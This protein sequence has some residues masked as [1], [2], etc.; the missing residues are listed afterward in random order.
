[1]PSNMVMSSE[2]S[3]EKDGETFQKE[4]MSKGKKKKLSEN[5]I[6]INQRERGRQKRLNEGKKKKIGNLTKGC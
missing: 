4:G 6:K 3:K 2:I 5:E 1:M